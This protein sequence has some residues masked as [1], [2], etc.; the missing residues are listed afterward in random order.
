MKTALL[1]DESLENP[2]MRK[3]CCSLTALSH[4]IMQHRN[5][6]YPEKFI[7]CKRP[8]RDVLHVL[9]YAYDSWTF[10]S[11]KICFR[12]CRFEQ[13]LLLAVWE[14]FLQS[15]NLLR[16]CLI[17]FQL[18]NHNWG[19]LLCSIFFVASSVWNEKSIS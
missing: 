14:K 13:R 18:S 4:C 2:S 3:C 16:D 9:L 1:F 19:Y 6:I 8:R 12:T 17:I 10:F 11:L 15:E 7:A 5:R